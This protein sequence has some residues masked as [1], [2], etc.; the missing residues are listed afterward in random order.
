MTTNFECT[1][2]EIQSSHS[3]ESL[4]EN[5]E[6]VEVVNC[7][8][9]V[10]SND[11][12]C[13]RRPCETEWTEC[14]NNGRNPGIIIIPRTTSTKANRIYER[15][16][17]KRQK[18]IEI[19]IEQ[20]QPRCKP[21][22]RQCCIVCQPVCQQT[23]VRTIYQP[24][25]EQVICNECPRIQTVCQP[26]QV[27]CRQNLSC[28][29]ICTNDRFIRCPIERCPRPNT[30]ICLDFDDMK[31]RCTRRYIGRTRRPVDRIM[32]LDRKCRGRGQILDCQNPCNRTPVYMTLKCK[33]KRRPCFCRRFKPFRR[34]HCCC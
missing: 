29:T 15:R 25:C 5:N 11:N 31:P 24:Q 9:S 7:D 2:T 28:G 19:L 10:D 33:E 8:A 30:S 14:C 17:P 4:S 20:E 21:P 23:Q 3:W 26:A 22:E 12:C 13:E 16:M 1:N 6:F 27:E 18:N 34:C 32:I